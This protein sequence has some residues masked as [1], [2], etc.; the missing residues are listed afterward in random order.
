MELSEPEK[1]ITNGL[2]FEMF[3]GGKRDRNSF[4]LCEA[5]SVSSRVRA[6]ATSGR[7][8]RCTKAREKASRRCERVVDRRGTGNVRVLERWMSNVARVIKRHHPGG[9]KGKKD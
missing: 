2:P 8:K 7:F 3:F 9:Y 6:A 4:R 5:S 1:W